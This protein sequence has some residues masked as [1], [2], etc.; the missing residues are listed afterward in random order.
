MKLFQRNMIH[1]NVFSTQQVRFRI[2]LP[3][4]ETLIFGKNLYMCLMLL[5]GKAVLHIDDTATR[6][7][8]ATLLYLAR[9]NYGQLDEAIREG[10]LNAW[11]TMYIGCP[12]HLETDQN[13]S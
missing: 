11:C 12:N 1:G 6:F 4:K 9:G 3:T 13:R 2:S 8:S 7:S 5:D 10:F